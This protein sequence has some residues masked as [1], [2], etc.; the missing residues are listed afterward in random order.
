MKKNIYV[1]T[2]REQFDFLP[3]IEKPKWATLR[4]LK[5]I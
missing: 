4:K 3:D 2:Q 1:Y 5:V